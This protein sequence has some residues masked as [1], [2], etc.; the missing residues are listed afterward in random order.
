MEILALLWAYGLIFLFIKLVTK[1]PLGQGPDIQV[2]PRNEETEIRFNKKTTKNLGRPSPKL[3]QY[4]LTRLVTDFQKQISTDFSGHPERYET[5]HWISNRLEEHYHRLL[6]EYDI[7]L[8]PR[9]NIKNKN[10][11]RFEEAR[12]EEDYLVDKIAGF[13]DEI[14]QD[15]Y[16]C[17]DP[18]KNERYLEIIQ[19]LVEYYQSLLRER[20][21]TN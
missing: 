12:I 17:R 9:R 14:S 13:F 10:N 7:D 6:D 19:S 1:S 18:D 20:E 21:I 4:K 16:Y 15:H 11:N 8:N 5:L 2:V 3:T